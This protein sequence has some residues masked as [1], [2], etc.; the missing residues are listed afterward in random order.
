MG[1]LFF[2]QK[3]P[4][5]TTEDD[6]FFDCLNDE[7]SHEQEEPEPEQNFKPISHYYAVWIPADIEVTGIEL[8]GNVFIL[9]HFFFI[10]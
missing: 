7:D 10:I 6:E 4:I 5:I 2:R 9:F 3:K 8:S 1:N